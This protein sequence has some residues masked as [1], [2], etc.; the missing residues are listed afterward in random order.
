[1]DVL[2][3]GTGL[4]GKGIAQVFAKN[5]HKVY[6]FNPKFNSSL[7]AYESIEQN[8]LKLV[9]KNKISELDKV[10]MLSNIKVIE[11]IESAIHC[12]LAIEA[13]L[14]NIQ[15]KKEKFIELDS[16]LNSECIIASNTSSLSI[17]DIASVTN[18]KDKIV[19][20][21]FF[22]PAPI[23]SLVEIVSGL[24]TSNETR[25]F[26]ENIVNNL[27]K[28]PVYVNEAPGFIV[29]RML[30]PMIN[31]AIGIYSEGLATKED[32]DKAMMHGANHPIGPLALADLI[33]L[34][35]CLSIMEVL[36]SE[37][38]IDKYSPHPLLKKMVRSNRLGRKT[39]IGF[40]EY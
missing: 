9:S 6:L 17:T 27:G 28:D 15:L 4:M 23:M 7:K 30:I 8:L 29:N 19:G 10:I 22:N 1:M 37:F 40:Y 16:I 26:V 36:H 13:V 32:I 11:K 5:G 21:H 2:V 35:V 20:L 38:G 33:G 24:N 18:R 12:N 34:D 3:Y 14:E 25:K 31:E 39:N